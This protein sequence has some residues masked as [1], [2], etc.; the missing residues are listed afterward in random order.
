METKL[1]SAIDFYKVAYISKVGF[2]FSE[3]VVV[4]RKAWRDQR[5]VH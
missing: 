4:S 1:K 3:A 5:V 2:Q